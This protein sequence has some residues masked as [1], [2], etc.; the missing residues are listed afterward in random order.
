[1]SPRFWSAAA[2]CLLVMGCVPAEGGPGEDSP[3]GPSAVEDA[4][5]AD[6]GPAIEF[7]FG[8]DGNSC[9][10]GLAPTG[11]LRIALWDVTWDSLS[12]QTYT[13][14]WDDGED[15]GGGWYSADGSGWVAVGGWI[16]IT[17]TTDDAASG[18]YEVTTDD[19]EIVAGAFEEVRYC[20]TDPLCG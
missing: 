4:C 14:A 13:F 20:D 7:Q 2:A 19:G 18:S 11:W 3:F 5:A 15:T 16:E 8:R 10:A 17:A 9:N 6:D 12:E 1:M